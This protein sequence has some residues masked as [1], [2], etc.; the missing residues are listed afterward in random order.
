MCTTRCGRPGFNPLDGIVNLSRFPADSVDEN[1]QSLLPRAPFPS[2]RD[3]E[4][5]LAERGVVVSYQTIRQW[6]QKFGPHYARKLRH[7]KGQ[8]GDIWH[9]DEGQDRWGNLHNPL[10]TLILWTPQNTPSY[11]FG[12]IRR[13][14][15]TARASALSGVG[16]GREGHGLGLRVRTRPDFLQDRPEPRITVE[17]SIARDYTKKR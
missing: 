9:L 13:T 14:W 2:F 6:C 3:V 5:L 4:E 1:Q 10:L 16:G 11:P 15:P 8:V 12:L 17:R 7:K